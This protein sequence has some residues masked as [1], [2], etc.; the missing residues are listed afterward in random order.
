MWAGVPPGVAV[1]IFF[2]LMAVV[3]LLEGMQIAFFL[4]EKIKPE[5][6]GNNMWAN[7]VNGILFHGN[8]FNLSGFM[9]G[10]QLCVVSCMFFIA[11]CT[12][13]NIDPYGGETLWGVSPGTQKFFN[14][15]FLGA[16]ITTIVASIAWQL[17][18]SAFPIAMVS[19]PFTYVLLR[20]CLF[21][22]ATGICNGAYVI[23]AIYR[24]IFGYKRDEVYIGTAYERE[25][26]SRKDDINKLKTGAGHLVKL[27]IDLGRKE[28]T[29]EEITVVLGQLEEHHV[30]V[31]A[32]IEELQAKR[33]ILAQLDKEQRDVEARM[34]ELQQKRSQVFSNTDL[35][36]DRTGHMDLD[37]TSNSEFEA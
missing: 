10:R 28:M 4:A 18:A 36:A 12:S 27:P 25:A 20:W 7:R 23:A 35:E 22:E 14:M 5:D 13:L 19:N 16:L 32:R 33:A 24:K 29:L 9:I 26:K 31:R 37:M 34:E 1:I 30:E 3:G 17:V 6:R 2:C 11:R 21:L 8:A 15:G